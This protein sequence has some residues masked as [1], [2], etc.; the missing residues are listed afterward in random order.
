MAH[1]DSPLRP[2]AAGP[3]S[4]QE[5]AAHAAAGD[6]AAFATIMR[7][8]NRMLFRT[9]RAILK[10][11]VDAED[12]LQEA[13]L[14]AWRGI[15]GFRHEAKLS[16]W[17][18]RIVINEAL[19]RLRRG[20]GALA[21]ALHSAIEPPLDARCMQPTDDDAD[22]QPEGV[23]MRSELRRAL[24]ASIDQLPDA[25]RGVFILR[26]VEELSVEDVAAMLGLPEVTVRTRMF[27]ARALLRLRLSRTM[28]LAASDTF[29]FDGARCDR[30]VAA[31]LRRAGDAAL[32]SPH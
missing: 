19:A 32:L 17:L 5:L 20:R 9:A 14:R 2:P 25:L 18:A 3:V 16:T 8:H 21:T 11:D 1:V 10:C 7:R 28:D 27:R 31:V 15:D 24:E 23:A 12:A 26:A 4:D 29:A 22:R 13:Y 30:L 6:G